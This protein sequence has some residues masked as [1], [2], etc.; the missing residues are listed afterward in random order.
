MTTDQARAN[1]EAMRNDF[2]EQAVACREAADDYRR[3]ASN[4]EDASLASV[5][6][7]QSSAFA[8]QARVFDNKAEDIDQVLKG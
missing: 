4:A 2:R 6:F 8:A 7:E 5:Q 3:A 1:L